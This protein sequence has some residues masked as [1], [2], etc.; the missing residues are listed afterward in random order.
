MGLDLLVQVAAYFG[1]TTPDKVT[2]QA[3]KFRRIGADLDD[4]VVRLVHDQQG[5]MRLNRAGEL[6]LL[7]FTVW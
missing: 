6:N 1:E 7:S 5:A 2:R 4:V 3:E